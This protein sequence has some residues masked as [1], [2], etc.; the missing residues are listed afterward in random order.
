MGDLMKRQFNVLDLS[1]HNFLEWTVDAQMNLK[2]QGLDHTI[3]DILV[4]GT[5]EIKTAI[6]QEKAKATVLIRHHLHESLKTEY[7]LVE[8]PKELWDSLKERYGHH[9]R[10]L[11]PKAQFDWTNMRFQDF[12]SVSEYN[13]T[14]FKIVSLLKYCDQAVTEDQMIEKTLSTFHANNIVLQQ[15]YRERGFKKYSELI[16]ILLVAEHNN[17]LLLKNHNLRPTGSIV[18]L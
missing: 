16:S 14:L 15:Q 18:R 2:A 8:N 1:G 5:T 17:D 3:K 10:V 7:L 11:L 13:S 6:E 9:K 12:K 4:S